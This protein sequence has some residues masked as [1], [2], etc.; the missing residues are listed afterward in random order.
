MSFGSSQFRLKSAHL[1]NNQLTGSLP[2]GGPKWWQLLQ[3]LHVDGNQLSGPLPAFVC[4]LAVTVNPFPDKT[5]PPIS[6][7]SLSRFNGSSNAFTGQLPCFNT[8]QLGESSGSGSGSDSNSDS[9]SITTNV[10]S[11]AHNQLQ[12]TLAPDVLDSPSLVVLELASNAFTGTLPQ[13]SIGS[14]SGIGIGIGFGFGDGSDGIKNGSDDTVLGSGITGSCMQTLDLHGNNFSGRIPTS[15]GQI[16]KYCTFTDTLTVLNL[17]G[18]SLTG[19]PPAS[20]GSLAGLVALDLSD[21]DM[22][23]D[24][25]PGLCSL[26]FARLQSCDLEQSVPQFACS[27]VTCN[28]KCMSELKHTCQLLHDQPCNAHCVSTTTT[29]TTTSHAG[30]AP[31]GVWPW[32]FTALVVGCSVLVVALVVVV[33]VFVCRRKQ[34]HSGNKESDAQE[35]HHTNVATTGTIDNAN[36]NATATANAHATATANLNSHVDAEIGGGGG[37]GGNHGGFVR[38]LTDPLL[39]EHQ[40]RGRRDSFELDKVNAATEPH[41]AFTRRKQQQQQQADR[42]AD[43]HASFHNEQSETMLQQQRRRPHLA[44]QGLERDGGARNRSISESV[45]E[46]Q[47]FAK[48]QQQQQHQQQQRQQR[49]VDSLAKDGRSTDRRKPLAEQYALERGIDADNSSSSSKNNNNN[50]NN[51]SS[52]SFDSL[53]ESKLA[54]QRRLKKERSLAKHYGWESP[55]SGGKDEDSGHSLSHTNTGT[56]TS[57]T[58]SSR[59][60]PGS[61][62]SAGGDRTGN[63]NARL[64]QGQCKVQQPQQGSKGGS[65]VDIRDHTNG[66]DMQ[67]NGQPLTESQLAE[68]RR[69]EQERRFLAKQYALERELDHENNNDDDGGKDKDHGDDDN[70]NNNGPPSTNLGGGGGSRSSNF[71]MP[72]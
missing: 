15:F 5:E 52:S 24:L 36:A 12:G 43:K 64:E 22:T 54:E 26:D 27:N 51:G 61:T 14:G 11:V 71:D 28:T 10:F 4:S 48:Q 29:G 9:S 53:S 70:D 57:K 69:Q 47:R 3:T 1:S 66:Q 7:G 21:N 20:L 32:Y 8:Q 62:T 56:S 42:L 58:R 44:K 37:G 40:Q 55:G 67:N 50:N 34:Q 17:A 41:A 31:P 2:S 39:S 45:S 72:N 59:P 18:N 6:L 16:G 38:E 63:K 49:K 46:S 68:Q 60:R 23:G 30:P 35:P 25:P 13:V 33:V 19:T 65:K